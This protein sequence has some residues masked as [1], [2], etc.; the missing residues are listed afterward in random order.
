[1]KFA[2]LINDNN[3]KLPFY[4]AMEE[5]VAIKFNCEMFFTWQVE[6]TV[7]FG[8]NQLVEKEVNINY[9]QEHGINFYRRKS[10]GGCVYADRGNVMLSFI[11]N[12]TDN[13]PDTMRHYAMMTAQALN[14]IDIP[15]QVSGRNDICVEGKKISGFAAH[16]LH[17][18]TIVHSTMLYD[19]KPE[20]MENAISPSIQKLT[21][22]GVNSVRAHVSSLSECG[23]TMDIAR[24]R[25]YIR[26]YF[27]G[28]EA[29]E[30]TSD[31]EI[32]IEIKSDPYYN[33][34]WLFGK[35]PR[36]EIIATKRF[37][38]VGEFQVQIHTD[39]N[40]IAHI[41]I[42]GDFFGQPDAA[43]TIERTLV[44]V[45][46]KPE[47]VDKALTKINV[48]QLIPGMENKNIK[49]LIFSN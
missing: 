5:Y 41:I 22:K 44:G 27:C 1:M 12:S 31:D 3:R 36:S 17:N 32:K 8:R 6:P 4:L 42:A 26:E 34:S 10:G 9:C 47:A 2:K 21:S 19:F 38:A 16:K 28:N 46:Y 25:N 37:D 45:D 33:N 40:R 11:V 15:A 13:V 49:Q 48:A 29:V 14:A 18:R 20:H 23:I 24:F 35:N 7:I 43:S 30:L 39:G